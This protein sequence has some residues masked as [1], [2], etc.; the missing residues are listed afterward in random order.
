MTSVN[1]MAIATLKSQNDSQSIALITGHL[2]H[3]TLFIDYPQVISHLALWITEIGLMN[4]HR[5]DRRVTRFQIHKTSGRRT[6]TFE[7]GHNSSRVCEG[8]T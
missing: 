2:V 3:L 6:E 4:R 7:P 5:S 1:K 8:P